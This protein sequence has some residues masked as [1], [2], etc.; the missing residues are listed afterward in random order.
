MFVTAGTMTTSTLG[1]EPLGFIIFY[2]V[3]MVWCV[4][5]FCLFWF[6]F[7]MIEDV[8]PEGILRKEIMSQR[9]DDM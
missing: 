8:D 1:D 4:F 9:A 2:A 5:A 6:T 7:D 3:L